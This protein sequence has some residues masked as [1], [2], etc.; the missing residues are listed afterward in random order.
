MK[1]PG[2]IIEQLDCY[3]DNYKTVKTGRSLHW[4]PQAGSV[5]LDLEFDN[6]RTASFLVPPDL[7]TIIIHFEDKEQWSL[8]ELSQE[9]ELPMSHLRRRVHVWQMQGVL[10][11]VAPDRFQVDKRGSSFNG[12]KV[13]D[14]HMHV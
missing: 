1:L 13:S 2:K 14:S 5:E 3:N 7:A 10:V 12:Q 11:E 8:E 9:M 4:V 6:G